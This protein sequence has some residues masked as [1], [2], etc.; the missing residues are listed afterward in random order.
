M[1]LQVQKHRL[2]DYRM[3]EVP[4]KILQPGE[5]RLSIDQ[6]AFTANNITYGAA[7]DMLGYWQFF[8]AAEQAEEHDWGVIPVWGFADVIESRCDEMPVGDRIYGY[9]PPADSVIMLPQHVKAGSFI[10]GIAHRQLLPPLYNRYTR[11]FAEP[12]YDRRNDVPR[13]LLAPL[14]LTSYCIWDH[15]KQQH[16]FNAEQVIIISAS[17]K[18]SLGVAVAL[19]RDGNTPTVIGLTSAAN[20]QFVRDTNLYD[21]VINY[22]DI[23]VALAQKPSVIVDMAGNANV[24]RALQIRLGELL[25]HYISVGLTHWDEQPDENMLAEGADK[26]P[27]I[28]SQEMFFAPTYILERTKTL[29]P[30]EFDK[31][32]GEFL[33]AA[34]AATFGWMKVEALEGLEALATLYPKFVA[35]SISPA[36]GYVVSVGKKSE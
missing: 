36:T 21:E 33:T 6:F 28:K 24:R 8:P 3:I 26:I 9:F 4:D 23:S 17:S 5:I 35:G 16:W 18:T 2:T 27:A 15:I 20:M 31:K 30:G 14:H 25:Q 10:D 11:V 1:E 29:A 22:D 32:S 13:M 12:N 7:G 19:Q 34:A